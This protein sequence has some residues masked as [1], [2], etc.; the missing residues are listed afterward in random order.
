MRI[1]YRIEGE[2][3]K[4]FI[5]NEDEDLKSAVSKFSKLEAK[6]SKTGSSYLVD[7]SSLSIINEIQTRIKNPEIVGLFYSTPE[8]VETITVAEWKIVNLDLTDENM[9]LIMF[10]KLKED[11]MNIKKI[12]NDNPEK[13]KNIIK[14][15]HKVYNGMHKNDFI[16]FINDGVDKRIFG[17]LNLI[18]H[19]ASNSDEAVHCHLLAAD[20]DD[21]PAAVYDLYKYFSAGEHKNKI[22]AQYWNYRLHQENKK[23]W[24]I[25]GSDNDF[26]EPSKIEDSVAKYFWKNYNVNIIKFSN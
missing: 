25:A 12:T 6:L 4:G 16:K 14:N 5:L 9:D 18:S 11:C 23:L 20:K 8:E 22:F 21:D 3:S 24:E 15:M 13:L 7:H 19:L 10:Q 17:F 26:G 2:N 1:L